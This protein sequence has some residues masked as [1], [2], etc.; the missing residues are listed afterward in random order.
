[1]TYRNQKLRSKL[2]D[3]VSEALYAMGVPREAY[4]A[5]AIEW[6]DPAV[7][8]TYTPDFKISKDVYLEAKGLWDREDRKKILHVMDQHPTIIICMVF[9]NSEYKLYKGSKTTYGMWCDEHLIPWI[10]IRTD[11]IPEEWLHGAN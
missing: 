11:T 1:M 6:I 9:Y 3:K 8:R 5:E 10:D 7:T 4:E 2:E